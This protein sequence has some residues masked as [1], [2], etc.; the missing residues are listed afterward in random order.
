MTNIEIG[1]LVLLVIIVCYM[2]YSMMRP[3]P[4]DC[5][6]GC[7]GTKNRLLMNNEQFNNPEKN[8]AA[9]VPTLP[10]KQEFGVRGFVQQ[11]PQD[12]WGQGGLNYQGAGDWR[13]PDNWISQSGWTDTDYGLPGGAGGNSGGNFGWNKQESW[14]TWDNQEI[15]GR[16]QTNQPMDL[17][18]RFSSKLK[19]G[20]Q[21]FNPLIPTKQ[22][23]TNPKLDMQV[24][25]LQPARFTGYGPL[26]DFTLVQ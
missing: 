16:Q 10:I 19:S 14:E 26:P 18:S 4:Y 20:V 21:S 12:E 7:Q 3:D 6:C 25:T 9:G 13:N 8:V 24:S 15:L 11:N 1:L 17:Q 22:K 5:G 23:Y 2:I